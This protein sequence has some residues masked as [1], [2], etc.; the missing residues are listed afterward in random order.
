MFLILRSYFC[1]FCQNYMRSSLVN[2][3]GVWLGWKVRKQII[4]FAPPGNQ[5][6]TM[7]CLRLGGEGRE[8]SGSLGWRIPFL[9]VTNALF[10]D[11][12][13]LF[14]TSITP[15][16]TNCNCTDWRG[17]WGW[18]NWSLGWPNGQASSSAAH[19]WIFPMHPM[20]NFLWFCINISFWLKLIIRSCFL[21]ECVKS[22]HSLF[23][24]NSHESPG[25]DSLNSWNLLCGLGQVTCE[26]CFLSCTMWSRSRWFL[27]FYWI[28][29]IK[30]HD[31]MYSVS[32][33]LNIC[34][35]YWRTWK[36]YAIVIKPGTYFVYNKLF[37]YLI[38][39]SYKN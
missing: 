35:L 11:L 5:M 28:K 29:K 25:L 7:S 14:Q 12:F 39:N 2:W 17:G 10:K 18:S 36:V 31:S 21:S 9:L 34:V 3:S 26:I 19:C 13:F 33:P 8:K 1:V 4:K 23:L 37:P 22:S 24:E 6:D 32:L 38:R 15:I 27:I 30:A 16:N 20:G